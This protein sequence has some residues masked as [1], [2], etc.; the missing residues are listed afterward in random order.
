M[1]FPC[2]LMLAIQITCILTFTICM[3]FYMFIQYRYD[4]NSTKRIFSENQPKL[5]Y[6]KCNLEFDGNITV[7]EFRNTTNR[8]NLRNYGLCLSE[9]QIRLF[10]LT[11][12]LRPRLSTNYSGYSGPWIEDGIFCNWLTQY[13]IKDLRYCDKSDPI[14]PVYVPIF[15]TSIHRN[16]VEI[17]VKKEWL[18]EAQKVMDSLKEEVLYFTVLQDAEGFKKSKL[19]FRSMNNLIIFNAG[20]ATT[21]FK[22]VPIP[23]IKGELQEEGLDHKKDIWVSSTIVKR[24]FPVRK[25]LF[26]S[27]QFFNMTDQALEQ[28]NFPKLAEGNDTMIHYQGEKFKQVIQRSI[29]HL[30]PRGFGRTSFRLYETVQLGT[31]PIYIW[32][33]INWIPFGNLME[34]IGIILHVSEMEN[35]VDILNSIRKEDLEDKFEEIKKFKPWFTYLGV[36]YYIIGVLKK[37]PSNIISEKEVEKKYL[38]IK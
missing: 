10:E 30:C 1:N 28:E 36:T 31:I 24:H 4:Q 5:D 8:K 15:W 17:E 32:D 13:S 14:P 38:S 35:L 6:S 26:E 19:K 3:V 7:H 9:E 33:D 21:G 2:T 16:K 22:Q 27:F 18:S 12:N 23:L 29:F 11:K 34:R 25:K 20:G 37:L